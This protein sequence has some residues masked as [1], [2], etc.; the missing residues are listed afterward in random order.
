[1]FASTNITSVAPSTQSPAGASSAAPRVNK[2]IRGLAI[3]LAVGVSVTACG[4]GGDGEQSVESQ[5]EEGFEEGFGVN[6]EDDVVAADDDNQTDPSAD[7][8]AA[9]AVADQVPTDLLSGPLEF[10]KPYSIPLE[11]LGEA[12]LSMPESSV[13]SVSVEADSTNAGR[14]I[15]DMVT[16]DG[17]GSPLTVGPG[18]SESIARQYVTPAGGGTEITVTLNGQPTDEVSFIFM[19]DSQNEGEGDSADA[20]DNTGVAAP[21]TS[22]ETI[23]GMLGNDDQSDTFGFD[24]DQ[25]AVIDIGL[26]VPADETG[27]NWAELFYN[28]QSMGST[29]ANA[30]GESALRYVVSE[31]EVGEWFVAVTGASAY[32]MTTTATAQDD[33]ASGKDAGAELATAV[34]IEPGTYTGVLGNS[35]DLDT[36]VLDLEP[37]EA[38]TASLTVDPTGTGTSFLEPMLNGGSLGYVSVGAGGTETMTHLFSADESGQLMIMVTGSE[39]DYTMELSLGAQNDA[40]SGTDAGADA[41]TAVEV[42]A[43][44]TFDGTLGNDDRM[45]VYTFV[46]TETG[47]VEY[48]VTSA[49][50]TSTGFLT[51]V[52][53]GSE[54]AYTAIPGGGSD[55]GEIEAEEGQTVVLEVESFDGDYTVTVGTGENSPQA[56]DDTSDVDEEDSTEAEDED[57]DDA[58][59]EDRSEVDDEDST[60]AD[61]E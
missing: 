31:E 43:D 49:G 38:L 15:V 40:E 3:A 56:D 18:G 11:R 51:P 9:G 4:G 26:T 29:Q 57:S 2:W 10:G 17:R 21:L 14:V 6:N 37:G 12:T 58:E 45:D 23:S 53:N 34:S 1:M 35:D 47:V 8:G 7:E 13:L 39:I 50:G 52:V 16:A 59:D 19:V 27:S 30:G 28:G 55:S 20:G 42:Q 32:E 36:Y 44:S 46:A 60:E 61:E 22:G 5:I 41:S 48:S 24:V 33:G 25:G 54:Q